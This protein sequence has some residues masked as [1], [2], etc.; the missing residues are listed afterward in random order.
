[1][2]KK[3]VGIVLCAALALS[4]A[5]CSIGGD[6]A[7]RGGKD[8][9]EREED[10]DEE[11]DQEEEDPDED[12]DG[13]SGSAAEG[14]TI[15][16]EIADSLCGNWIFVSVETTDEYQG[17]T[18]RD[19]QMSEDLPVVELEINI[20]R[21]GDGLYADFWSEEY[22]NTYAS[23]H[24]PL[25]LEEEPLYDG[26]ENTEW[27]VRAQHP[28]KEDVGFSMTLCGEKLQEYSVKEYEME[29]GNEI[30][31]RIMTFL[32]EGS[33]ELAN[34][35]EY[36]YSKTVEV[37]TA[38]ELVAAIDDNTHIILNEGVYDLSQI[39]NPKDTE[40]VHFNPYG[41]SYE[42]PDVQIA[43]V[44]QLKLEA[45]EGAEVE[46][47]TEGPL[48]P[49]MIFTDCRYVFIQGI[50]F[51]HHVEPG[52]CS[53]S[54][55]DLS[56]VEYLYMNNC[57]LYGCGTYGIDSMDSYNLS[58]DHVEIYEC[59]YG[60]MQL[61]NTYGAEFADCSMHDNSDMSMINLYNCGNI[62][63]HDCEFRNNTIN[64]E[65]GNNYFV[66]AGDGNY[67]ITFERCLFKDNTGG[68]FSNYDRVYTEDCIW[69]DEPVG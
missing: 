13:E 44:M 67:T 8:R 53:G 42:I 15:D 26:C 58:F 9:A 52:H 40:K 1:M 22:E 50:T 12:E 32:K 25:T 55:I 23:Y 60:I 46:I 27:Y 43:D 66:E 5:G 11:E 21:D 63:F 34:A 29:D 47:C 28:E 16:D 38:E 19:F 14:S 51:G 59:T 61:I 41:Y 4:I 18:N 2:K 65:F 35:S 30:Y 49:V 17:E 33:D 45:K 3:L 7:S 69:E 39:A 36:R 68:V 64:H 56:G 20:Y 6:G 48:S 54:V 57:R 10:E 37:S 31:T 62:D 24:L